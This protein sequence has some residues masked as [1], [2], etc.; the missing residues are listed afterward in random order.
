MLGLVHL[1]TFALALF[2]DNNKPYEGVDMRDDEYHYDKHHT[3]KFLSIPGANQ[4][5]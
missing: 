1:F 5:G 3:Q 4:P 2:R